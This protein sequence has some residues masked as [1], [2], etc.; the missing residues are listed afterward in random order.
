[1]AEVFQPHFEAINIGGSHHVSE[2]NRPSSDI[3][4]QNGSD[5]SYH[6]MLL[7]KQIALEKWDATMAIIPGGQT[8]DAIRWRQIIS[9]AITQTR[10]KTEFEREAL[11]D[12]ERHLGILLAL[13]GLLKK[14]NP[15]SDEELEAS[16]RQAVEDVDHPGKKIT[17]LDA[18]RIGK[19]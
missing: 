16:I 6:E 18:M 15:K 8:K 13:E 14:D 1:V 9:Q 12:L 19:Q 4:F 7:K 3:L 2:E 17:L 10:S 5:A 11:P